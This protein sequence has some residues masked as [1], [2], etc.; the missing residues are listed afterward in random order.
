MT[1]R[2]TSRCRS[3]LT[4]AQRAAFDSIVSGLLW[5]KWTRADAEARA[6]SLV[7]KGPSYDQCLKR[8]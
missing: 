4:A 7:A 8:I 1:D 3:D 2:E 5:H 6:F